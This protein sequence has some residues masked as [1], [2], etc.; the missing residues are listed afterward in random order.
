MKRAS[1]RVRILLGALLWSFG[2]FVASMHLATVL[3][4]RDRRYAITLHGIVADHSAMALALLVVFLAGGFLYVSSGLSPLAQLR[5]KL[6]DVHAG[7]EPRVTGRYP[8]EVQPLVEDLNALLAHRD[9]TVRRA[10]AKAGDLAH[11][12]KT[13]LAVIAHEAEQARHSGQP[14]IAGVIEAQLHAMK[15]QIE[16]HL[17]HAR[18][19]A[20]AAP[21]ARCRVL[22]SAA[23]LARTLQRLHASRGISIAVHVPADLAARVQREDLDEMLGNLLDNACKWGRTWVELSTVPADDTLEIHVDDDGPGVP[24][25]TR[26]AVLRRGVRAYE[27][28]PGSGLGLAIVRDLA[29]LYGGGVRLDAAAIGGLRAVLTLPSV[30]AAEHATPPSSP[31]TPREAPP[32]D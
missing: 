6:G 24:A 12:L 1:L 28:A 16:Y 4:L 14:E 11:G 13:P 23:G 10:L 29:E 27:A 25:E 5:R 22:D 8:S 31:A 30:P 3:M 21:G 26:T 7:R 15:R 17:A 32:S 19:A 9:E 2:L 18:A 20:G